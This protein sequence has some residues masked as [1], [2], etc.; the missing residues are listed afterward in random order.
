VAVTVDAGTVVETVRVVT[1][2]ATV[3][4]ERVAPMHE[5]ALE[6]LDALSHADAYEG[7]WEADRV[8]AGS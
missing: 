7:I 5:H 2:A 3:A 1:G 8:A 6:Y 4:V